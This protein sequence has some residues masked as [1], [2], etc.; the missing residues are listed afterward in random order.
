MSMRE[1]LF[2]L[3]RQPQS[4]PLGGRRVLVLGLGESGLS[5]S[6]WLLREGAIVRVADTRAQPPGAAALRAEGAALELRCGAFEPALL[7]GVELVCTSPGLSLEEPLVREAFARGLP[8]LGDIELFAW[9]V[10]RRGGEN[11]HTPAPPEPVLAITGTNGKTTATALTGH[12]LRSAGIDCEV[13]GNIGPAALDALLRR[14]STRPQAWVLELSSYQLETT[15]SLAPQAATL[16]NI[17]EDHLDRYASMADYAAAKVRIFGGA[18]VA[19]VNRDDAASAALAGTAARTE[20]AVS[21]G[22]DAP[23]RAQDWGLIRRSDGEWLARGAHAVLRADELAIAGRHNVANALA[24]C[25]LAGTLHQSLGV[26]PAA[27]AAGL[28]SFR[29]LPHRVER[30]A[31]RRGVIWYDDSKGT[32]V[33]ATLAALRGLAPRDGRGRV[34]LIAGGEGKGQ[35]FA[36]LAEP[37]RENARA[38]LL[39]GRDAPLLEAA[40]APGAVGLE[41]CAS[42]EAAVQ[43]AAAI[44]QPGDVVLLSPA[45]ASFDMFRDYR[46]RGDAFAAAL[47][48]LGG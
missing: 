16:L 10:R 42:L 43:R 44:A 12:L 19:V 37:V 27:L 20:A 34:V 14:A 1:P 35:N 25:A 9:A 6:R 47:R 11:R 21:Y 7:D 13:A 31:E 15:W 32:N 40:L 5:A 39:I 36:P 41:R 24:A 30:I 28:R 48:V 33:G 2:K 45:C 3:L 29:G 46:Q 26:A 17:S 4:V 18:R 8:I 23:P 22:L 38:V